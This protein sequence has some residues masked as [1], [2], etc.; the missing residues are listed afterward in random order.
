M[1]QDKSREQLSAMMDGEEDFRWLSPQAA[2]FVRS[3][4]ADD[5]ARRDWLVYAQIGD[6]LRSSDLT[7]MPNEIDFLQR[8]SAAIAREPI[9]LQPQPAVA[10]AVA[11]AHRRPHWS[12]RMAAGMAAVAGVAVMAWV[13]LPGLQNAEQPGMQ[14]SDQRPVV[15]MADR[16]A[17]ARQLPVSDNR[18]GAVLSPAARVDLIQADLQARGAQ[19]GAQLM[20]QARPQLVPVSAQMPMVEYL[21][22]HQQMAGGMMPMAPATLRMVETRQAAT[23]ASSH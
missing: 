18:A 7:P 19:S 6:V 5:T 13:A 20:P 2:A 11:T 22:A 3:A 16:G 1:N 15:A 8:V 17:T 21:L 23:S 10:S 4:A 14:A 9:V 12:T